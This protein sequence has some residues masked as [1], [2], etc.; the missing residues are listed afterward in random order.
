VPF[1]ANIV[2]SLFGSAIMEMDAQEANP[3]ATGAN[4]QRNQKS[5]GL[6]QFERDMI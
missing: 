4:P 2:D 3:Q 6:S 1:N 5:I